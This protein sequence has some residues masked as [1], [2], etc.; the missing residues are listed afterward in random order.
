MALG[1]GVAGGPPAAGAGP[2]PARDLSPEEGLLEVSSAL[3]VLAAGAVGSGGSSGLGAELER[4]LGTLERCSGSGVVHIC[5]GLA[6]EKRRLLLEILQR[7]AS[8]TI[9]GGGWAGVEGFHQAVISWLN[10]LA[11]S[12]LGEAGSLDGQGLADLSRQV[13]AALKDT[14]A[15]VSICQPVTLHA[16]GHT[17]AQGPGLKADPQGDPAYSVELLRLDVHP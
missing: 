1:L 9:R 11:G 12:L 7:V 10:A 5:Q 4:L 6:A 17:Q 13:R 2:A 3:E 16:S 8:E 15:L 14:E